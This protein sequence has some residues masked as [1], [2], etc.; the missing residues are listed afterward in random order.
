MVGGVIAGGR[1]VK[2]VS[3]R[4]RRVDAL[5]GW[6][7]GSAPRRKKSRGRVFGPCQVSIHLVL[8]QQNSPL[9]DKPTGP[10]SS[11]PGCDHLAILPRLVA[12]GEATL[13]LST[14]PQPLKRVSC[15]GN[16]ARA[17]LP[18]PCFGRGFETPL[19]AQ[20]SIKPRDTAQ[21]LGHLLVDTR[22][23]LS[24]SGASCL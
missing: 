20:L 8:Q 24:F 5:S 3:V 19:P 7:R 12:F 13:L 14:S 4:A 16:L 21:C 18:G 1:E 11:K 23:L 10:A 2:V 22:G 15:W 9:G 17:V 6:V